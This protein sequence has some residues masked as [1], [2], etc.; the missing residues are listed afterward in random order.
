MAG[1]DRNTE[2]QKFPELVGTETV[3]PRQ[4][5]LLA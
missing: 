1:T 2:Q 5:C 3:V 4:P